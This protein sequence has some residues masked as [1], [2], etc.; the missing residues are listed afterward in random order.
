MVVL[1]D[2]GAFLRRYDGV[3]TCTAV[4]LL[5]KRVVKIVIFLIFIFFGGGGR[6]LVRDAQADD[7]HTLVISIFLIMMMDAIGLPSGVL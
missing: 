3:T 7:R 6:V 5:L 1:S 4:W 2:C